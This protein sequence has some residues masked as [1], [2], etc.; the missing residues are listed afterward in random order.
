MVSCTVLPKHVETL[1]TEY[2]VLLTVNPFCRRLG[3][4]ADD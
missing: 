2:E 4:V 1:W 3:F